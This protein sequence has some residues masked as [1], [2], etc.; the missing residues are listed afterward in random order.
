MIR[1]ALLLSFFCLQL[2]TFGQSKEFEGVLIYK[3][4]TYNG[5]ENSS[6][7]S[8]IKYS[9]KGNLWRAELVGNADIISPVNYSLLVN[10]ISKEAT[11]LVDISNTKMAVDMNE[12]FFQIEKTCSFSSEPSPKKQVIA[13]LP[14]NSG[15]I[16]NNSEDQKTDTTSIWYTTSFDAIP[17]QFETATAPGLIVSIQQDNRS[18]WELDE[19]KPGKLNQVIFAVP[20]EYK[21]MSMI[22]F[23]E[24]L[25]ALGEL[26]IEVENFE[27]E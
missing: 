1:I 2:N 3:L 26:E 25:T 27:S 8:Q 11:I 14:C 17:F 24:Y 13:G 15:R 16:I 9:V 7:I 4:H 22:E 21:P 12:S 23:Q 19:I 6:S 18:F 5:E 10:L 20:Q